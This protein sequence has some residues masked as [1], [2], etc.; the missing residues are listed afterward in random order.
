MQNEC[1][2]VTE[3]YGLKKDIITCLFRWFFC[4]YSYG[5]NQ[6]TELN[7]SWVYR[8]IFDRYRAFSVTDDNYIVF[9]NSG[10]KWAKL[11]ASLPYF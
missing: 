2:I 4:G 1:F 3:K 8:F 5:I 9:D 6:V 11:N 10:P 7:L